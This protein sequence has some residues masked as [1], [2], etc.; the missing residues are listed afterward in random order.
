MDSTHNHDST[1]AGAHPLLR[2]IA[3]TDNIQKTIVNQTRAGAKPKEIISN[4][5]LDCDKEDPILKQR[6]V[7]NTK[8]KARSKALGSL[9]PIQALLH[10]LDIQEDWFMRQERHMGNTA[11]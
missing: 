10:W 4:L 11:T 1:I 5:R 6:D 9:T 3:M 7:Y 8:A 2:K